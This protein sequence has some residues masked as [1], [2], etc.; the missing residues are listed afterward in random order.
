MVESSE[1][2]EWLSSPA[3][4]AELGV[5]LRTLYRLI[6]QDGL[7][8][9]RMGRVIRLRRGEITA[10]LD[11]RRIQSGALDHLYTVVEEDEVGDDEGAEDTG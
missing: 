4:A 5:A 7:P 10:W 11:E 9:Y 3:A 8:A 1:A 6:D 2:G